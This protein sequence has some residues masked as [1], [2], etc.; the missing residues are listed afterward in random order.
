MGYQIDTIYLDF[1]KAFEKAVHTILLK[2]MYKIGFHSSL[3]KWIESYLSDRRCFV[4]ID[5]EPSDSYIA[6]SGVP[7]GS[8]LGPLLFILFVN[9]VCEI[10]RFCKCL[11]YADDLKIFSVVSNSFQ[12]HCLQEDLNQLYKWCDLNNLP[13][14]VSKCHHLSYGRRSEMLNADY[15]INGQMVT[16][17]NNVLDLGVV[18]D[19]KLEFYYLHN[20]KSLFDVS[21]Y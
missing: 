17:V 7:Q 15:F 4:Y 21:V 12:I 1:S 18:F 14:N 5:N 6:T 3:L 13:L 11:L 20:A 9:D 8:V 2:K 10:F 19:S 16:K